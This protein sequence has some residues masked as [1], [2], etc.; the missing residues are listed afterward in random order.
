MTVYLKKLTK[1]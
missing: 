1:V